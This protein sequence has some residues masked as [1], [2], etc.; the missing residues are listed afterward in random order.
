MGLGPPVCEKCRVITKSKM[1]NTPDS[2]GNFWVFECEFCGNTLPK[3][4]AWS[5][6]LSD[7]ELENNY[8]F[9]KFLHNKNRE[10][11]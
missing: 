7:E 8:K 5:C 4:N 11:S 9:L 1:N 10:E 2:I 6:G 3:W